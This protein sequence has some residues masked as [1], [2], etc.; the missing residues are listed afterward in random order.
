MNDPTTTP[1]GVGRPTRPGDVHGE[2]LTYQVECFLREAG[3]LIDHR[4]GIGAPLTTEEHGEHAVAVLAYAA[5]I[6]ERAQQHRWTDARA[7]LSAG[8]S[9]ERVA[10]AMGLAWVD[11]AGELVRQADLQL[12][13]GH[14]SG[15]EHAELLTLI[16]GAS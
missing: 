16:G 13:F 8:V 9:G 14:I 3:V 5:A 12:R 4:Y 2:P 11:V 15:A 10:A 7:A 6:A 1:D